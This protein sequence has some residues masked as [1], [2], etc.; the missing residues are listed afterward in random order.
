MGYHPPYI[1]IYIC[2][3]D[4]IVVAP[5]A[6]IPPYLNLVHVCIAC[7]YGM[8]VLD[9]CIVCMYCMSASQ[10]CSACLYCMF[11]LHVFMACMYCMYVRYVVHVEY[12]SQKDALR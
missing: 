12:K 9:V 7:M 3:I 2:L 10:V 8:Y 4:V 11:A 6:D 5:V 1:H